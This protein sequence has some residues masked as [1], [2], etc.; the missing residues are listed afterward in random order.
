VVAAGTAVGDAATTPWRSFA[1]RNCYSND[2][3]GFLGAN[4]ISGDTSPITAPKAFLSLPECQDFC[5][6]TAGCTGVEMQTIDG[7]Q[8]T[9][10]LRKDIQVEKCTT[11]FPEFTLWLSPQGPRSSAEGAVTSY[12]GTDCRGLGAKEV[13]PLPDDPV[14]T[15]ANIFVCDSK[16]L[17]HP[18]CDGVMW[19]QIDTMPPERWNIQTCW[20]L[21]DIDI[22]A[23]LQDPTTTSFEVRILHKRGRGG[24]GQ[25]V[26]P[27]TTTP[28]P[29]RAG[30]AW[31]TKTRTNCYNGMGGVPLSG[32]SD[33]VAGHLTLADCQAKCSSDPNCKAV[34]MHDT[35][36]GTKANCYLRSEI[37]LNM[38]DT[39]SD[40][41]TLWFRPGEPAAQDLTWLS[42]T[43]VHCSLDEAAET[44][45]PGRGG[46]PGHLD[47]VDCEKRCQGSDG[48]QAIAWIDSQDP[49]SQNC[50]LRKNVRL[51]DCAE[52]PTLNML[53]MAEALAHPPPPRADA[54]HAVQR[55]VVQRIVVTAAPS[56]SSAD[57]TWTSLA[58]RDCSGGKGGDSMSIGGF[59]P[60]PGH[61]PLIKCQELCIS[62]PGCEAVVM[63][64]SGNEGNC[65]LRRQVSP[66]DCVP[67]PTT[68]VWLR[69]GTAALAGDHWITHASK[70]CYPGKG[71]ELVVP[72][73][74][75]LPNHMTLEACQAECVR[76]ANCEGIMYHDAP[77]MDGFNCYLRKNIRLEA[78]DQ[79]AP[80]DLMILRRSVVQR[81][82]VP[83]PQTGRDTPPA[84]PATQPT[85]TT[86]STTTPPVTLPP[87]T[88]T[89]AKPPNFP[90]PRAAIVGKFC[91]RHHGGEDVGLDGFDPVPTHQPLERCLA[92]CDQQQDCKA[93]VLQETRISRQP[94][95]WLQKSVALERCLAD[96]TAGVWFKPNAQPPTV[97]QWVSHAGKH[98]GPSKGADYAI[99]QQDHVPGHLKLVD[100]Q[101]TCVRITACDAYVW[102][103]TGDDTTA[104]CHL[105]ANVR[106]WE[107]E[108]SPEH[109]LMLRRPNPNDGRGLR[110]EMAIDAAQVAAPEAPEP[111]TEAIAAVPSRPWVSVAG[112][113]CYF[114]HGAVAILATGYDPVAQHATLSH[115]QATCLEQPDCEAVVMHDVLN[116]GQPN[117]WLR[118]NIDLSSCSDMD[119]ATVWFRPS[120]DLTVEP[121]WTSYAGRKCDPG[122]G[123]DFAIPGQDTLDGHFSVKACQ[124]ACEE[125]LTCKAFMWQS[126]ADGRIPNCHLR[127]HV[128][129]EQCVLNEAFDLLVKKNTMSAFSAPG[130]DAVLQRLRR[131]GLPA[132]GGQV[133]A[134][135]AAVA[136]ALLAALAAAAAMAGRARRAPEAR[137]GMRGVLRELKAYS[138]SER[139]LISLE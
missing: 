62:Q 2:Q 59:D 3:D 112:K 101:A 67:K 87:T 90:D 53:I 55:P 14:K 104:N 46:L 125:L 35:K 21:K 16:C 131:V 51:E 69:P 78:C 74:D 136:V 22:D 41:Y 121:E 130:P 57:S 47:L 38:C 36:D 128:D 76:K 9:C 11:N 29:G 17:A 1:S 107:C 105:R 49:T 33:P 72:G 110:P 120:D 132:G 135:L 96:P 79:P 95:C 93:V 50:W 15:N 37:D 102:R 103:D 6:Q 97:G 23:C 31:P 27:A 64:A 12:S 138:S 10:W 106:P 26:H 91:D 123:A 19:R 24:D 34:V 85:S 98:C 61:Y 83:Q 40:W 45:L 48:C 109:I 71:A 25:E 8:P 80:F 32:A 115:C 60:P 20:L 65:G 88:T 4:E 39:N 133:G 92:L 111:Q 73:E 116:G 82:A 129:A 63:V 100:C 43:G 113:D 86:P 89:Q 139:P 42:V 68:N 137:T 81:P 126:T 28:L 122:H 44:A 108:S 54:A 127:M 70:N 114:G 134:V 56:T 13:Q 94:N 7:S 117:C 52:S 77:H 118:K 18:D 124:V 119:D 30:S 99:P 5:T 58:G 66:G 84:P 75:H